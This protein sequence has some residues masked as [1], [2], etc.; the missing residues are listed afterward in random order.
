MLYLKG[1]K[2]KKNYVIGLCLLVVLS[3]GIAYAI[4]SE[5]IN[6]QGTVSADATLDIEVTDSK[7]KSQVGT[8][9]SSTNIS[10]DGNSVTIDVPELEYPGATVTYTVSLENNGTLDAKL[11]EINTVGLSNEGDLQISYSGITA[12]ESGTIVEAE[13]ANT[14]NFDITMKWDEDSTTTFTDQAYS[15]EL[16]FEQSVN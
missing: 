14:V 1:E 12:G 11:K 2:M 15:I 6:I 4:M 5:T 8:N 13:N 7:I 16:N 3:L 9:T 10:S